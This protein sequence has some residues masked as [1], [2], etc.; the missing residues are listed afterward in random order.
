MTACLAQTNIPACHRIF[1]TR[2]C[3]RGNSAYLSNYRLY[4]TMMFTYA[5][6]LLGIL[7]LL[8]MLN[9]EKLRH[10]LIQLV[11]FDEMK[12]CCSLSLHKHSYYAVTPKI[13]KRFQTSP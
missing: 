8:V 7:F 1:V 12:D 4:S 2:T 11:T 13:T 5:S 9:W 10:S 6:R 3:L